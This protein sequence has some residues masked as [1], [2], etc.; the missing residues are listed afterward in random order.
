MFSDLKLLF[1]ETSKVNVNLSY[2]FKIT[3]LVCV[4]TLISVLI[5][6]YH[7]NLDKSIFRDSYQWYYVITFLNFINIM[8]IYYYYNY[9]ENLVGLPGV[10]GEPGKKGE[11]GKFKNCSFCKNN[12]FVQKTNKYNTVCKVI[13]EAKEM[14]KR[15]NR[16]KLTYA[17]FF[18]YFENNNIDYSAIIKKG[19]LQNEIDYTYINRNYHNYFKSINKILYDDDIIIDMFTYFINKNVGRNNNNFYGEIIR[20]E[21]KY[22]YSL[23]GDT[24]K[25][26]QEDF[27]LNAF[28][29]SGGG[30]SDLLYPKKINKIVKFKVYDTQLEK[31]VMYNIWRAESRQEKMFD[32]EKIIKKF[33]SLGDL[34]L[35][36]NVEPDSHLISLI[37][38]TCLQ[39]VDPSLMDMVFVY[40][41]TNYLTYE[42]RLNKNQKAELKKEFKIDKPQSMI[43]MFSVWRTPM[44]TLLVSYVNESTPFFNN[45]L[46]YNLIEGRPDLIDEFGNVKYKT[47]KRV[48]A[49]LKEIKLNVL[50]VIIILI[51]YYNIK[52]KN[53]LLYKLKKFANSFDETAKIELKKF[54]NKKSDEITLNTIITFIEETEER[55][56]IDNIERSKKIYNKSQ[57][58][59]KYSSNTTNSDEDSDADTEN[60][61]DSEF[62]KEYSIGYGNIPKEKKIPQVILNI[63]EK[64]QLEITKIDRKAYTIT[65]LHQLV[66]EIFPNGL[67][68]RIAIDNEGLAEGGE[69]L[70]YAQEWVFYFCKVV[71][72]P[73]KISY[74]VKNDCIGTIQIDNKRNILESNLEKQVRK[75]KNLMK[76]IKVN[77]EKYCINWTMVNEYQDL[78]FNIISKHVGHIPDYLEKIDT[79]HFEEFTPSRIKVILQEYYKM[80]LYL[81][82]NCKINNEEITQIR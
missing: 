52:F 40:S 64:I 28:I 23:F 13:K 62:E 6:V 56:N 43:N 17:R 48:I 72:P 5:Y 36:V 1:E 24:V 12:L 58:K 31:D 69:I 76:K 63:Y 38:T 32:S 22:G 78:S 67:N 3:I 75:Y 80:N 18:D 35:P 21:T 82:D 54:I 25:G 45:T 71:L 53:Q 27:N 2:K 33:N 57:L 70:N 81:E 49:R 26:G 4:L 79:F 46:M 51:H 66:L 65:N 9:K 50:Q 14:N 7:D 60:I 8:A 37:D 44:N 47:K 30:G 73:V 16:G 77:P 29:V 15:D 20:P 34:I 39:E 19:L 10:K 59:N 68:E 11:R 61:D 74:R 41:D 55:Y 42:K